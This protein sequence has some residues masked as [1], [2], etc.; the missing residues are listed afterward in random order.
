MI[1]YGFSLVRID[2]EIKQTFVNSLARCEVVSRRCHY[3]R[4]A[5][6]VQNFVERRLFETQQGANWKSQN[7]V[8]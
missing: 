3:G 2:A 4:R 6:H 8:S 1:S 7:P 5:N